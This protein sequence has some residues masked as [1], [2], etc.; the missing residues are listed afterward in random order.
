MALYKNLDYVEKRVLE[1]E[2]EITDI[3]LIGWT[4]SDS[5]WHFGP[6]SADA[7][8]RVDAIRRELE[9]IT[10]GENTILFTPDGV[11]EPMYVYTKTE[12]NISARGRPTLRIQARLQKRA[13]RK[14]SRHSSTKAARRK[15]CISTS[16]SVL[17]FTRMTQT[18]QT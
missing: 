5:V 14:L 8:A 16:T 11:P 18:T 7:Y 12:R 2:Q 15:G 3:C 13:Q 1:L 17:L 9:D 10:D 6:P 4:G